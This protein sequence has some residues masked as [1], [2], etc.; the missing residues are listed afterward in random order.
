MLEGRVAVQ[1]N[2][3]KLEKWS[4]RN[5][6][7]FNKLCPVWGSSVQ[8]RQGHKGHTGESPLKDHDGDEGPGASVL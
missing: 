2:L 1:R 3:D 7:K 8:G 6:V 4:D 5:L